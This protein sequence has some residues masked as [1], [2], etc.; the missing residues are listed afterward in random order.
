MTRA[1][2]L[3]QCLESFD[4]CSPKSFP[5]CTEL[6]A[7]FVSTKDRDRYYYG[8]DDIFRCANV[9][10]EV[11]RGIMQ[12]CQWMRFIRAVS[13]TRCISR[14]RWTSPTLI[15]S[16]F[17]WGWWPKSSWKTLEASTW[18]GRAHFAWSPSPCSDIAGWTHLALSQN[19]GVECGGPRSIR[20][21]SA[22]SKQR[23]Q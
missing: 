20:V 5:F 8:V 10:P 11:Q 13:K 23:H 4:V 17:I 14:K 9:R 15:G 2:A 22:I 7:C 19:Q 18:C 6:S 16:T 21:Y 3:S 12:S 1:K